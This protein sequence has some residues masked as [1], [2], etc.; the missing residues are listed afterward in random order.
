MTNDKLISIGGY[1]V[2]SCIVALIFFIAFDILNFGPIPPALEVFIFVDGQR[3]PA[4]TQPV[5]VGVKPGQVVR[6]EVAVYQ[7]GNPLSPGDF[8][9]RWCFEPPVNN[10]EFCSV[11]DYRGETYPD[12]KLEALTRQAL[13][14]HIN[15]DDLDPEQISVVF[16]SK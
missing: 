2:G 16:V 8:T 9:Y 5:E 1:I 11:N 3:Y 15:H 4:M 6:I 12:Y 7:Q 14:L 13:T 10:N